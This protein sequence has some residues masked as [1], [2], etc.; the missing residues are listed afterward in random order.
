[1]D[2]SPLHFPRRRPFYF[3][4]FFRSATLSA[5]FFVSSSSISD[6]RW[7]DQGAVGLWALPGCC[8]C[9]RGGTERRPGRGQ[10][11][12]RCVRPE[13]EREPLWGWSPDLRKKESDDQ[14]RGAFGWLW[15]TKRGLAAGRGRIWNGQAA[16]LGEGEKWRGTTVVAWFSSW[17]G[18]ARR[19]AER[20]EEMEGKMEDW[21]W[22]REGCV[23]G[24]NLGE[25][26]P[27]SKLQGRGLPSIFMDGGGRLSLRGEGAAA[28]K[29]KIFR[30]R[31]FSFLFPPF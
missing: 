4:F 12:C 7:P 11:G 25:E 5:R 21:K 3:Y 9:C 24:L 30:F 1:M 31:F 16:G 22:Q 19:V 20:E 2:S 26:T 6:G 17:G 23:A 28:E 13:E 18:G 14:W 8:C 10:R 29:A 15:V 27:N